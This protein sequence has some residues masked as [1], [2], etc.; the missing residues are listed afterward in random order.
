MNTKTKKIL[1]NPKNKTKKQ[2]LLNTPVNVPFNYYNIHYK[3]TELIPNTIITNYIL[4]NFKDYLAY[5]KL[6]DAMNK[7]TLNLNE[8]FIINDNDFPSG[9]RKNEIKLELKMNT[10]TPLDKLIAYSLYIPQSSIFINRSFNEAL[11]VIK[12]QMGKDITRTERYINGK[13]YNQQYY[14]TNTKNNYDVADL[15]YQNII[16]Y[17]YKV[18]KNINLNIVNKFALLSCQNLFNL[19]T[20]MITIQ[21]NKM[22]EPELNSVFRPTKYI[23]IIIN[24][25]EFSMEF[26]F[27]SQLIISRDGEP[28][29][30]T[31][32][33]GDLDLVFY[34]EL[35]KNYYELKKLNI[36]Y[37]IDKC[38]PEKE[39]TTDD[40][41][42]E[43]NKFNIKSEYA[44]PAGLITAGLIAA[45]ILLSTLGGKS[46]KKNK[47]YKYK[48]LKRKNK[49][50][51]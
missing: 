51:R 36:S 3:N 40:M 27:K 37:D 12:Y 33:C 32:P 17:M 18:N 29:D 13:V 44:I 45:P 1:R 5:K 26:N 8:C 6:C 24:K 11:E 50:R 2:S 43:G 48:L 30:P 21:V 47:K 39:P 28:L 22:L 41:I 46:S 15:F 25:N 9:L 19:L 31:Y 35:R 38:G 7:Y 23:N 16:D 14:I 34:I 10:K 42:N 4:N 49:S 20:D